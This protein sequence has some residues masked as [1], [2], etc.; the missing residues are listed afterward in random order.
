MFI[1][2]TLVRVTTTTEQALT[3]GVDQLDGTRGVDAQNG[4]RGNLDHPAELRLGILAD[5][6]VMDGRRDDWAVLGID[7]GQPDFGGELAAV[8]PLS[9]QRHRGVGAAW[10]ICVVKVVRTARGVYP[11]AG[12]LL[13]DD[14]YGLVAQL[15]AVVIEQTL[16]LGVH[17]QDQTA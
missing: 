10:V 11:S 7:D 6:D 16:G 14:L 2:R 15:V 5:A 9:D 13:E 8:F 3:L 1:A 12:R 17:E 4:V